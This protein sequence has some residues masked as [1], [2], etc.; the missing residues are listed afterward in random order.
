MEVAAIL[1]V[2]RGCSVEGSSVAGDGRVEGLVWVILG[3][4]AA[5]GERMVEV[6]V[7]VVN[8]VVLDVAVVVETLSET[9]GVTS[10][11]GCVVVEKG[12]DEVVV[13][14]LEACGVVCEVE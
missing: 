13:A 9:A 8:L 14:G 6:L 11:K 1:D 12:R 2:V 3:V 4:G 7:E 10:E 5:E